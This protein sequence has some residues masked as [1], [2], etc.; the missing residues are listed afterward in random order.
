MGG[1]DAR[2]HARA[3]SGLPRQAGGWRCV[4]RRR[5]AP[6]D[7]LASPGARAREGGGSGGAVRRRGGQTAQASVLGGL[8]AAEAAAESEAPAQG[9]ELRRERTG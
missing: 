1:A 8:K 7:G 9:R 2:V 6:G 3:A 5:R 4:L